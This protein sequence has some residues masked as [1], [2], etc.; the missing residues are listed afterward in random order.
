MK[1]KYILSAIVLTSAIASCSNDVEEISSEQS[2]P[3][4]IMANIEGTRA[5]GIDDRDFFKSDSI[6]ITV[7]G[8]FTDPQNNVKGVFDGSRWNLSTDIS[9]PY[10]E[11][12]IEAYYPYD[13]SNE[14]NI[15]VTAGTNHLFANTSIFSKGKEPAVAN[16]TFKHVMSRVRFEVSGAS[17]NLLDSIV[18][19]GSKIYK[20]SRFQIEGG[21]Y[22]YFSEAERGCVVVKN[23]SSSAENK[24]VLDALLIPADPSTATLTL[25]FADGKKYTTTISLP[26]LEVGGYYQL[27][28]TL[29]DAPTPE[30]HEYVDLGLPS[31]ILWATCNVGAS[32]PE[33]F[34]GFYAWGETD[35]KPA[36]SWAN[37]KF[38]A[39][40]QVGY[41]GAES[42]SKYQY[43]DNQ[44]FSVW[45]SNG[46]F[47]GD[48]KK[49]LELEDDAAHV[50]WG[51]DWRMPTEE[52][53]FDLLNSDYCTWTWTT[54][55]GIN[56]SLVT[57]KLNGNSIFLPGAGFRR[58]ESIIFEGSYGGYWSSTLNTS[59]S[60]Q[61]FS[62][63][64]SSI[65]QWSYSDRY[66]GYSVRP[67]LGK[68][69]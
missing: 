61:A 40:G 5:A 10:G 66:V 43:P 9:V 42:Y 58:D 65:V 34:G 19:S 64:F 54:Q 41:N 55:N 20:R 62:I 51:G 6:G 49:V 11:Y 26:K 32:S 21:E 60:H 56:G 18:V 13:K 53:F 37:N 67:V 48:G 39:M 44:I 36:Y 50:N 35:T 38:M 14:Y 24:Q 33:E 1:L 3:L 27:P 63:N 25:Y 57:S 45:Y 16:L 29:E 23:P 31:G 47:I 30:E 7:R 46:E 22:C 8:T 4:E 15:Y 68:K 59:D 28:I 17:N 12:T 52:E 69:Q 2:S